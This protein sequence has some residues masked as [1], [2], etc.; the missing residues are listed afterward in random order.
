[1]VN[2]RSTGS[3]AYNLPGQGQSIGA[4][5][6]AVALGN[7]GSNAKEFY[8]QQLRQ[9]SGVDSKST[10]D[11]QLSQSANVMKGAIVG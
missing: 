3:D 4:H 7:N 8:K 6:F 2:D 9:L 10:I 11:F 1:M 5:D